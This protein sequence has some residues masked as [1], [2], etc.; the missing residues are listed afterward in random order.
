MST[1]QNHVKI[2]S[3]L[4]LASSDTREDTLASIIVKTIELSEKNVKKESLGDL[5]HEQFE[6]VPYK[7]ELESI[8]NKLLDEG[9]IQIKDDLLLLSETKAA[10]VKSNDLTLTD[11]DKKRFQNFKSFIQDDL[12]SDID[13][14]DIK[15]IWQHFL[16][17]LYNCFFEYGQ[18]AL[19]TLHPHI[20]FENDSGFESLT[21]KAVNQLKSEREDL[22]ELFQKT[23]ELFPNYASK[24]DL[25]FLVE[26]AQKTSSFSSLGVDPTLLSGG[27][28]NELIDWTLYLDTNVLYSLLDLHSHPES[29]ASKALI[30]LIHDN[31]DIIKIK[32]R[33]SEFTYRELK[34]KHQD[35]KLLDSKM[36]SPAISALLKSG[37]VDSFAEQ[38]YRKL[39]ENPDTL[40]PAEVVELSQ[41]ELK[42]NKIEIGR[43]AKRVE[44][45]GEDY[46]STQI[47][48]YFKY[49][50]ERNAIREE[51]C[52]K[53]GSNFYPVSKSE[54][55]VRHDIT[56][57]ELLRDSRNIKDGQELTMNNIKFFGL[58][59]DS[60]LISFDRYKTKDYHDEDTYPIF[61]KP[62]F[63]LDKLT[64]IL[65]VQ[66][67]DY[68]KAFIKAITTKGFHRNGKKSRDVLKLVNYLKD[69]GIDNTDVVYNLI[70]EDLFLEKL[71]VNQDSKDFNK[72]EFISSEINRQFEEAQNQLKSVE[73]KLETTVEAKQVSDKQNKK[74][75]L[76]QKE[77]SDLVVQYEKAV[78]TLN[79]KIKKV[80][81]HNVA[82]VQSAIDF[83]G[84]S[85]KQRLSIE[86]EKLRKNLKS[87]VEEE[88][89]NFKD[90]ALRKWQSGVWWNLLWVIPV[91][92]FALLLLIPNNWYH[93]PENENNGRQIDTIIGLVGAALTLFFGGLVY[94]R[95]LNETAK[96]K[97]KENT[98]IP[99]ELK[100]KLAE[101]E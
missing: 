6:F 30:Q 53:S 49:I 23:I 91:I 26:L 48:D 89:D 10:E 52:K 90:K 85:E 59:L 100:D 73:S 78:K 64:R 28:E 71:N 82:S 25:N 67:T 39:Q 29:D 24:E 51:F 44:N 4:S 45:I 83:E 22:T 50:D 36:S 40:H 47:S 81:S 57:R 54:G 7:T 93:I 13:T 3:T 96:S 58:T 16:N 63:L 20:T 5:I 56:L 2:L 99:K 75:N 70:S 92:V 66:T 46:I 42:S 37:K 88:I 97:K 38:F 12:E 27:L 21:T 65:P 41:T 61:F 18:E 17:Y 72:D 31:N 77:A 62:S 84:E 55:Q 101:F 94:Y 68:K 35:F 86:N 74:L 34:N 80:E 60:M 87:Q 98:R 69:K 76:S 8:T 32:L 95:Y 14:A 15:L 33:Y 79:K 43:N 9:H 11:S 19:K 1:I